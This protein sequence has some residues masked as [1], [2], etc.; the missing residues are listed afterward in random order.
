MC[1]GRLLYACEWQGRYTYSTETKVITPLDCTWYL[2]LVPGTCSAYLVP[3]SKASL[4]LVTSRHKTWVQWSRV[5][6]ND[7]ICDATTK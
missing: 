7:P 4:T 1:E 3:W 5:K 2:Y 6:C